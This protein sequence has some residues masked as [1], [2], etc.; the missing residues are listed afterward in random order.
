SELSPEDQR[1]QDLETVRHFM[2]PRPEDKIART[3]NISIPRLRGGEGIPL[4]IYHPNS[5]VDQKTPIIVFIH[6][7]G[8]ITGEFTSVHETC[9]VLS[10]AS[11]S[12]VVSVD[13]R[14]A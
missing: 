11:K 9:C 13:Y 8:F 10:G 1:K 7:G 3:E 5:T 6:G 4:K 2:G 12:V 14:L